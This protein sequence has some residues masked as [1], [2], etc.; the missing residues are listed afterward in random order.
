MISR[1]S[2]QIIGKG[3]DK[4]MV[5]IYLGEDPTTGKRLYDSEVVNGKKRD[6]TRLLNEKLGKRDN[7][8]LVK[9]NDIRLGQYLDDW[10]ET[11]A[12]ARIRE[13]TYNSYKYHLGHYLPATFRA[14]PIVRI[15]PF[16]VQ[17]L[18][19]DLRLKYSPRTIQYVHTIL[20]N[21][22]KKA[23]RLRLL[24][25][26]PCDHVEL[27]KKAKNEIKVFSPE[28]AKSFLRA[29]QQNKHGLVFEFALLTGARP[30]EYLAIKWSDIDLQRQTITFQ[31][32]LIWRKGGG[33]Y[34]DEQMKTAHSRR[35]IP[36]P[37]ELINKL[38]RH[39]LA[40]NEYKLML[41]SAYQRL[42]LVFASDEGTPL[43]SGNITK[44]YFQRILKDAGLGHHKLYSLRHSCATLLLAH[45]ENMK[46][47]QERL[48]HA[49]V[50]LTLST[51]SHVLEGMQAQA[52]DRL[53]ALLYR[54]N[55]SI[56][57]AAPKMISGG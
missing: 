56:G 5:R 24:S 57:R 27:P 13:A 2:G 55:E 32:T 38:Q 41:G 48:G 23:V 47:I 15:R 18:Y 34:F 8:Q 4:W 37:T 50:N 49:D 33:F 16:D 25:E 36:L 44:R 19:N 45:G 40:Q 20:K 30:E 26:N 29:A 35:T 10:V 43:H 14:M 53:G 21:A 28:E 39:R 52:S 6:A 12:K 1:R 46:V 22:L 11:V 9:K 54:D 31:R 42:D 3:K 51:Y 7:G 17:K